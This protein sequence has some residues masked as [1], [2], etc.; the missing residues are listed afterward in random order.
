MLEVAGAV[1][2]EFEGGFFNKLSQGIVSLDDGL[3]FL[4]SRLHGAIGCLVGSF[5]RKRLTG[6][7]GSWTDF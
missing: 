5:I 4:L 1:N 2:N 3:D 7:S 6:K